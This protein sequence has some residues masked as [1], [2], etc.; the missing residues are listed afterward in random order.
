M[1]ILLTQRQREALQD[2]LV[3]G[4][5][6]VKVARLSPAGLFWRAGAVA[7][8]A[9]L[10]WWFVAFELAMILGIAALLMTGYAYLQ[11]E[12]LMLALTNKRVLVRY[13]ALQIDVVDIHFDK[14]ESIEIERMITGY[15]MGYARVVIMGTGTR[16]ISIP[17]VANARAIRKAYN[18][19]TLGDE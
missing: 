7:F 8:L 4:E 18:E 11:R 3:K 10:F 14:I 5:K 2:R 19:L 6:I 1:G 13:G 17:Y 12:I 16:Y 9:M 15:M